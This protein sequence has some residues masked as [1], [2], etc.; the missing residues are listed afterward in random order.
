MTTK[1]EVFYKFE[2]RSVV[3]ARDREHAVERLKEAIGTRFPFRSHFMEGVSV[4]LW[5]PNLG[6]TDTYEV[7]GPGDLAYSPSSGA[8]A[9]W[10]E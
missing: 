8:T 10:G 7:R 9:S 1:Y 6:D 3:E 4:E 5:E 2:A